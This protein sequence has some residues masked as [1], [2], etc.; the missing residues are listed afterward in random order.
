MSLKIN[1]KH[2]RREESVYMQI[3]KELL[4]Y[5]RKHE[6]T[7]GSVMPSVKL[8]AE[9]ANVSLRTADQ[10]LCALIE[11][12]YCYRKPKRGTFFADPSQSKRMVCGTL[13]DYRQ[14]IENNLVAFELQR[15]VA[16]RCSELN[17]EMVPLNGNH[18]DSIRFY[19]RQEEF[20]FRGVIVLDS[21]LINDVICIAKKFKDNNFIFLNYRLKELE[22]APEN[23]HSVLNQ[24]K[25]GAEM[26][27]DY[28]ASRGSKKVAVLS[29]ELP[30]DDLTYTVRSEGFIEAI[31]K[32]KID[33]DRKSDFLVCSENS[34]SLE[35]RQNAYDIV[36]NYLSAGNRP[37]VIF[38]VSDW[39]ADG[40]RRAINDFGAK[41]QIMVSGYDCLGNGILG[42]SPDFSV[43]VDYCQMGRLAVEALVSSKKISHHKEV[44]PNLFIKELKQ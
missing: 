18:E 31:S 3:K 8:I 24:D 23:L 39:L 43:K 37:E 21:R 30:V 28:F 4:A 44:V 41:N 25:T 5:A 14:P 12:G 17:V 38:A 29:M 42:Y 13:F 35:I 2:D 26:M 33:F 27:V 15:G 10:A 11:D 7:H 36:K 9:A 32:E 6:F 34:E 1:I 20:D 19:R 16:Q 22:G 40:A